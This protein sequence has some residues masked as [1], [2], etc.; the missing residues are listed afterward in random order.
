MLLRFQVTNHASLLDEQELSLVAT[1]RHP[2]RA[3]SQVPGGSEA[4]VPVVAVYGSDAFGKSNVVEPD[5][6]DDGAAG[7]CGSRRPCG[8]T[9]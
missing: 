1:D 7:R 8:R 2:G 6:L 4:A 9:P 5:R 3:E